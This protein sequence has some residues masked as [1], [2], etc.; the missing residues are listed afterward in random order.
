MGQLA[1]LTAILLFVSGG[2]KIRSSR[3]LGLGMGLMP[4]AEVVLGLVVGMAGMAATVGGVSLPRWSI[5]IAVL[6]VLVSTGHHATRLS[7][8]RRRRAETEGGRLQTHLEYFSGDGDS[9]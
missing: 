8:R 1:T 7:E 3:R 2:L 5:P 9:T 6:L 4:L